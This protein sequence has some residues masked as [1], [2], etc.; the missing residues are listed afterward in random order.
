[1]DTVK[2]LRNSNLMKFSGGVII[3]KVKLAEVLLGLKRD[4]SRVKLV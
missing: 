2:L 3:R 4:Q 1:M